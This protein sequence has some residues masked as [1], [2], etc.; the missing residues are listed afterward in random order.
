MSESIQKK[1]L[2]VK[3]PR[4]KITYDLETEGAII[5]KELPVVLAM[6][7]DYSGNRDSSQEFL[8]YKERK[9]IYIDP[10]NFPEV[11]KSMTPRVVLNIPTLGGQ[12]GETKSIELIFECL[13]DFTPLNLVKKI[14]FLFKFYEEKRKLID[15]RMKHDINNKIGEFLDKL[16]TDS[17]FKDTIKTQLTAQT[18]KELDDMIKDTHICHTEEQKPYICDLLLNY[19]TIIEKNTD[20]NL[21]TFI[22][23]NNAYIIIV[24]NTIAYYLNKILHNTNFQ[25][26]ESSWRGVA[27]FLQ[28]V[29]FNGNLK[30]RIFNAT[31]DELFNDLTKS[32]EFDQSILFK[33]IY[34]EEYG[35]FGGSPYTALMW[36]YAIGRT[37]LD[38]L[39]LRKMTEVMAAAHCPFFLSASAALFDLKSFED[40]HQPYAIS[41]IFDS[42]ELADFKN[43]RES[44]DSKYTSLLL[45]RVMARLP[46]DTNMLRIEGLNFQETVSGLISEEYTWTNA[47]YV[48]L[49]QVA[50][51][52][53]RYG[54]FAAICGVENGGRVDNLPLHIYKT[55]SGE[56]MVKCPTEVAITDRREKE[57]SDLGFIALCNSKDDNFSVFFGSNSTFKPPVFNSQNANANGEL[58]ARTPYMLNASRFAHY[59]KCMM[60]DK[61]GSFA[62]KETIK[63]F[64]CSWLARYTLLDDK[65]SNN[66]KAEYPLREFSISI[67]EVPGKP[68]HYQSIFLLR[69]HDELQGMEISLRL[70]SKMPK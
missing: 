12:E 67:D 18:G 7:G 63:S 32:M 35:T 34:E 45:P 50:L 70:V 1:L 61:I 6:I 28:N 15:L 44:P 19:I 69:P 31:P 8:L 49:T 24:D 60:R 30:L 56:Y 33:K 16:I 17:S 11:L 3:P 54:W 46:Y 51:A 25:T 57:L 55:I 2:R 10:E 14:D 9:F 42:I 26:L 64:L 5:S 27:Y 36:D 68:G 41:K 58:S 4:I 23:L 43:F 20:T 39:L 48:Y 52:Y 40:L 59:L 66:I 13:E 65:A 38:M 37:T 47:C 22:L 29:E 21:N 62:T 53:S